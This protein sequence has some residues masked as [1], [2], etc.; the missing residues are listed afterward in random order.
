M[1]SKRMK[2]RAYFTILSIINDSDDDNNATVTP[3]EAS[4]KESI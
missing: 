1:S 4:L 3:F 2:R